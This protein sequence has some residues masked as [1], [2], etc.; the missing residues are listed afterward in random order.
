MTALRKRATGSRTRVKVVLKRPRSAAEV[1][2]AGMC[3]QLLLEHLV[4][5]GA[6]AFPSPCMPTKQP[7]LLRASS[8]VL[9][10]VLGMCT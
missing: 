7:C 6:H 4:S 2:D 1:S 5:P 8:T 9:P 3:H 10:P